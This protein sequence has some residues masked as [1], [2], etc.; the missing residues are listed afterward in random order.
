M[1]AIIYDKKNTQN[2]LLLCEIEK[3]VPNDNEVLIEVVAVSVNAADY[4][5]IKMGIVPKRKIYGSD[6]AGRV[7]SV[8]KNITRFKV[9]DEVFG[10]LASCGFGGFAEYTLATENVLALKPAGISFETAATVPMAAVTAL[11]GLRNL[12][13]IQSG[14][15]VLIHGA[16]GGVGTF[17]V[18]LAK[19]FNTDVTAVC[20]TNNVEMVQS[21]GADRVINYHERDVMQ[22]SER[23]DLIM[24]VNGNNS[25]SS[26]MRLLTPMG[27]CV[28]AGGSLSQVI[29][30]ML[31]G[32][33]LSV[34]RKK[35]KLLAAKQNAKDLDYIIK[36]VEVGKIKPV[37]D[38][39]YSLEE[40]PEAMQYL[41][42]GHARGKV[43]IRI[44][45]ES[46]GEQPSLVM[47]RI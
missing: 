40:I 24:A 25:L 21:I 38:R 1:K 36:L 5:S 10:D 33:I 16:G 35:I 11:Q 2:K 22:S 34:G 13:N 31:F 19:N 4:R 39:F 29:K 47:P 6:I 41:T 14:Q 42:K 32:A 27:I 30:T 20:G 17:A 9:G 43:V 45:K 37:I 28:M 3:P 8:G 7:V 18:Q 12:G 44:A 23:Y 46:V 26:Y 15:K